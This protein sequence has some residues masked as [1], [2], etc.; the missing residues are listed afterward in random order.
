[1]TSNLL[2][3]FDVADWVN[4]RCWCDPY[5]ATWQAVAPVGGFKENTET[6][7]RMNNPQQ[8]MVETGHLYVYNFLV[9]S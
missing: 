7:W 8:D 1:M 5:M 4:H 2:P 3:G 6:M 9:S